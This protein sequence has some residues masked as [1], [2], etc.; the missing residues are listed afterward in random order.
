[1]IRDMDEVLRSGLG[2]F[3]SRDEIVREALHAYIAELHAIQGM[4]EPVTSLMPGP[5][6]GQAVLTDAVSSI[7][8]VGGPQLSIIHCPDSVFTAEGEPVYIENS[9]M[10]GLHNRDWPSFWALGHLAGM[11]AEEPVDF[12]G[13]L[14]DVTERA[15]RLAEG[16][17]GTMGTDEKAAL[18]MLPTNSL[19]KQS[20]DTGFQS[21]AI[22]SISSKAAH[23]GLYKVS[24]PLPQ[25]GAVAFSELG[26]KPKIALT[27][28]GWSLLKIVRSLSP[29]PPN[30]RIVAL[31]FF[32][33]LKVHAPQDWWGF[34]TTV[35][36]VSASP[37]RDALLAKM[38][39]ARD[40]STSIAASATQG[41]IARCREWGL[42][43]PK[44]VAGNYQLTDFGK[45]ILKN[46]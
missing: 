7:R 6:T 3:E 28:A 5:A 31:E 26:S 12:R 32:D 21:F 27:P 30:P 10:L 33:Y 11:A 4:D 22:G 2:G 18:K 37:V 46:V 20:A 23:Q 43:E 17:R 16:F 13:F 36:E 15:W 38:E 9:P 44:L 41:Y 1:M 29:L 40:W 14:D 42:V 34:E 35:R 39:S 8:T 25:W 19:K 24:G 45:E